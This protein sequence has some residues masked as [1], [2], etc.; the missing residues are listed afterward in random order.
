MIV[1]SLAPIAAIFTTL[2]ATL[3]F[4]AS[5]PSGSTALTEL[6]GV[7]Q[8]PSLGELK[9]RRGTVTEKLTFG[10]TTGLYALGFELPASLLPQPYRTQFAG[11]KVVQVLLGNANPGEKISQFASLLILTDASGNETQLRVPTKGNQ[12]SKNT[13]Y[14]QFRSPESPSNTPDEDSLKSTYFATS[15][16]AKVGPKGKAEGV[17]ISF[18]DRRLRFYKRRVRLEI[19]SLMGTP[20]NPE[21]ADIKGAIELALF[22]AGSDETIVFLKE[23]LS[24]TL[25]SP[26]ASH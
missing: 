8:N 24:Q 25:R 20:F 10:A 7:K 4:G 13:V 12:D 17:A 11:E 18:S 23:I 14:I 2:V 15:G 26:L 21:S 16:L 9:F 22:S 1:Q 19:N 3:A 6:F 5:P